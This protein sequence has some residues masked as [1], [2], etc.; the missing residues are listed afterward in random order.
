MTSR[1]PAAA[2]GRTSS[3]AADGVVHDV[4]VIGGGQAGLAVSWHL[5][6]HDLRFRIL[7]AG[8][9][10]GHVWRSRWDSL[11]LFTPAQYDSLPGLAFPG[12]TDTYPDK[13]DVADY[14]A[15]YAER[16]A[17]PVQLDTRVIGLDRSGD[18]FEVRTSDH[19]YRARQVVVATGPFQTPS[20]PA[21][22]ARLGSSVAQLHSAQY[23][24]PQSL[25][26]GPALVVGGGNSGLQIAE[27]LLADRPVDL[28]VGTK[29]RALPQRFLGKDLFWWGTRLNLVTRSVDSRIGR[30]PQARGETL[31]G[32][33]LRRAERAGIRLRPRLTG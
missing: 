1:Q 20:I 8:S 2:V 4:I 21:V 14:L 15:A 17:L 3:S 26:A 31:V 5:K 10:V 22:A 24:A 19:A 28:A 11:R 29:E 12:R 6:R 18:V 16:F 9:E 7:D 27:E 32:T 23:R 33:S 13:D 25:P 30:R